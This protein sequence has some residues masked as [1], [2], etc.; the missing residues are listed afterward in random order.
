MSEIKIVDQ[1]I[2]PKDHE[3]LQ[4]IITISSTGALGARGATNT[5]AL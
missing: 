1:F 3:E 2:N 4:N 5:G